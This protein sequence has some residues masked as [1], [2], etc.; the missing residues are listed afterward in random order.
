MTTFRVGGLEVSRVEDFVDHGVPIKFLLPELDDE[1]IA[2]NRPWLAPRFLDVDSDTVSI[3]IQSWLLRTRHRTILVDTCVGNH[4]SRHF[5]PFNQRAN[6]YLANLKAAGVSPEDIDYV[7]CTHLHSDHVGWNT[8]LDNGRWVPTFPNAKHLFSKADFEGL[9]PR[10]K[11]PGAHD[12]ANE[13]FLDSVLPVVEAG[14]AEFVEGVHEIG[15]G[16]T[17][18]PAPGHSP[19]HCALRVEDSGDSALFTGDSM[20]HPM[21]IAAPRLNSFA[22][23]DAEL[24]RATRVKLLEECCERHRLLVPGHFAAPHRGRVSHN[25]QGFQFHAGS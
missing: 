23:A 19:G 18:L 4:K 12:D 9:D 2:Q 8:R 14:L 5:P 1:T 20:H 7:F 25:G 3:H 13:A 24:A 17:I 22:C 21:Q 10:G 15:E 16:L 11:P 6:P